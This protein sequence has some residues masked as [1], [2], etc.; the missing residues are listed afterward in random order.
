[1]RVKSSSRFTCS[2]ILFFFSFAP[3]CDHVPELNQKVQAYVRSTLGKKAG[4]GECWDLAAEALN[5]A[6]ADWDGQFGFGTKVDPLKEC[7]YPGDVIQF[8]NVRV[9]YRK[10]DTFYEEEM[11]QHT[12]VVYE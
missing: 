9:S 4:R 3:Y 2:I 12:A 8:T 1:M 5:R 10:G 6:G 11:D 7:V